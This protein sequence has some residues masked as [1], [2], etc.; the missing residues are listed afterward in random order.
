VGAALPPSVFIDV[1]AQGSIIAGSTTVSGWAISYATGIGLPISSVQV[2]V[3]GTVVGNATYGSLRPDVCAV[4]PGRPN[5][6]NVGYTY[7]LNAST[8]SAG[9]HTI[10]AVAADSSATPLTGFAQ[11]Q[12]TVGAALP[13]SVFID[14]PAQG[15]TIAGST[16]VSGW[17]IS[18]ATPISS[19]QVLVDGTVVGN[20]TY[21]SLR[22]DVCAVYPGRPNCPNVGYTYT[23]NASTLSAGSHTIRAVATDSSAT[24]LSSFAQIQVTH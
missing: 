7:T 16:T 8:L 5:C 10:R 11:V 3:D 21:G 19:V 13:P 24:P 4:Y 12:V 17:A 15:S 14:V 18:S 22:P 23:L 20:A 2:L 9:S 1:P 6:P